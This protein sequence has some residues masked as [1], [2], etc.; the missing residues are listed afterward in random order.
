MIKTVA[1]A[2]IAAALVSAPVAARDHAWQVGNDSMHL[3]NS[4]LDM[5]SATGRAA[6]LARIERAAARLC[7]DRVDARD[8]ATSTL[9]ATM[10]LPQAAPLRLAVAERKSV[11]LA[12][13]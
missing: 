6:L 12:S 7:R 3:Y 4:D 9:A 11:S 13:R 10:R 2:A 8:C 5:N 1:L